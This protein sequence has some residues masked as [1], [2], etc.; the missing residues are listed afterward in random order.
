MATKTASI[1]TD[2]NQNSA[3]LTG[4]LIHQST[5]KM[6]TLSRSLRSDNPMSSRGP[7]GGG[8]SNTDS[9]SIHQSII[10]NYLE[11]GHGSSTLPGPGMSYLF[12]AIIACYDL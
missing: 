11:S 12:F 5:V 7:I 10:Q 9:N 6:G 2:S 8:E 4:A 3:S 1:T